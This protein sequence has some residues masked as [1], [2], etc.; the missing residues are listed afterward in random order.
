[1]SRPRGSGRAQG[2]TAPA[3]GGGET[4]AVRPEELGLEGPITYP[5]APADLA[6][7]SW[8]TSLKYFGPGAII[9]GATIGSGET[10]FAARG[11]AV[12]GYA[13]LWTFVLGTLFKAAM[14]YSVNRYTVIA[15]EHPMQ[16]W[17]TLIPGPRGWFTLFLAIISIGSFPLWAGGL[18]VGI[19]DLAAFLWGGDGRVWATGALIVLGSLAWLGG[20][21]VMERVFQGLILGML[22]AVGLG[23]LFARPDWLD[24]LLGLIPNVPSYEPWIQERYAEIAARPVWVELVTYVGAIGGGTYDYI[25]Y[26]GMLR[27]KRWGLLGRE[28]LIEMENRFAKVERGAS[29]P[30]DDSPEEVRKAKA[31]A[32]APFGDVTIANVVMILFA[33]GFII[34]GANLL[35]EASVAPSEDTVLVHQARFLTVIA[36]W[37]KYLWY[38]AA[39]AAL[40]DTVYAL[41]EIYT[42]TAYESI[43]A[44]SERVRSAGI[45]A[46]RPWVYA[47]VG[48]SGLIAIWI[49]GDLVTIVTWAAILG[50]SLTIGAMALAMPWTERR[51]LPPGLRMRKG[52]SLLVTVS[53]VAL[54]ALGIVAIL[55]GI[56]VIP[57][58]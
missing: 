28:D 21:S 10:V 2:G 54:L 11:G 29:L 5:E 43:G 38:A 27:Q 9:A 6:R 57:S 7:F 40:G 46:I 47:Y 12:F 55:Q 4:T 42:H 3:A 36:P 44:F 45:R 39:F 20:Y 49:G 35:H 18:S 8:R 52:G 14:Q 25:G 15:G 33:L 24:A 26:A 51:M 34:Q 1:M 37:L 32:R 19:G 16:R 58:V 41:W 50:G 56:G 30:I 31:W 53:G 48:L 17:V 22:V 13:I 23:V